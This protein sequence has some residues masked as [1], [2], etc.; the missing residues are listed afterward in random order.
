MKQKLVSMAVWSIG[1]HA[2][3]NTLPALNEANN[4]ILK[5]IYTRNPEMLKSQAQIYRVHAYSSVKEMLDDTELDAIYIASPV[6]IHY[7]H[8]RAALQAHK[9]VIVEKS[10]FETLEQAEELVELAREKELVLMEAFMYRFHEQFI[11]LLEIIQSKR[12]GRVRRITASFGFPHLPPNNIRY[13][14]DIGGGSL[15]D[16]GA[17]PI[18]ALNQL[19]LNS[20]K[21]N[22]SSLSADYGYQVDTN[23]LAVLQGTE[24]AIAIASWCFGADYKNEIEVWC[25]DATLSVKRAFSKPPTLETSIAVYKNGVLHSEM[26][27]NPMNHFLAMFQYFAKCTNDQALKYIE[28]S[29]LLEQIKLIASI[30]RNSSIQ[31]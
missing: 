26:K 8:A 24:T 21:L 12:F 11:S 6:G 16:A 20:G 14:S 31:L 29:V 27:C 2:V 7:E 3:K 15:L 18:S 23:G 4:L 19:L 5:G 9:H 30:R 17:Y 25:E 22:Y 10:S 28:Y 13:K 1:S